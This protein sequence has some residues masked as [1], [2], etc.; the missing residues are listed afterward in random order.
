[1]YFVVKYRRVND[2]QFV[3]EICGQWFQNLQSRWD[4][5]AWISYWEVYQ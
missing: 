3:S 2:G 1:L 5:L 4:L